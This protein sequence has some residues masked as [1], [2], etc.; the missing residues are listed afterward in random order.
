MPA[1]ELGTRPAEECG[2]LE[3]GIDDQFAVRVIA[4]RAEAV[5]APS[6]F[7]A[8]FDRHAHAVDFLISNRRGISQHAHGGSDHQTAGSIERQA[9]HAF[10]GEPDIGH[11]GARPHAEF[12]FECAGVFAQFQVDPGPEIAVDDSAGTATSPAASAR[13]RLQAGS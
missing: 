12:I 4:V 13:S 2:V 3:A 9:L 6:Q 10:V 5:A 7:I 8:A 1:P 11:A